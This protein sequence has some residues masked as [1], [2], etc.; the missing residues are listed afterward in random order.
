LPL[1]CFAMAAATIGGAACGRTDD[2][3][4]VWAYVSAALFQ[5]SCA[6]ASCH[7]RA[8]AVAGLDFSDP[9]RGY[10]SLTGLAAWVP[11]LDVAPDGGVGDGCQAVGAIVYCAFDRPL[12][13]AFN[14]T[15]SRLMNVLRARSAPR[16]P[17]DRPLSEADISLVET[18]ILD[19]A[20]KSPGGPSAGEIPAS[21][22]G[23]LDAAGGH[24]G[25]GHDGGRG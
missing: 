7:S 1:A 11:D 17:P 22:D 25:G 2:R 8:R 4:A 14:P 13:S 5:P 3:P 19:G 24:G 6:T 16:M 12:V 20:R 23:G 18:W 21:T 10:T 9:D 15:Q